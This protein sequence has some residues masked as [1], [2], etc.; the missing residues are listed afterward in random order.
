M[1]F[2]WSV[3]AYLHPVKHGEHLNRVSNYSPY[4]NEL[5]LD[6]ITFPISKDGVKKF[7]KHNPH[8]PVNV[9]KLKLSPD[10]KT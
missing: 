3:L 10:K 8:I 7:N 5:N 9:Y 6:G 2:V 4:I 1:C